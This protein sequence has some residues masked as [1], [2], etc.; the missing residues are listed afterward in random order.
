VQVLDAP[1]AHAA[2]VAQQPPAA[3]LQQPQAIHVQ[4]PQV[5]QQQQV[6]RVMAHF[7]LPLNINSIDKQQQLDGLD[8]LQWHGSVS[9][10][11]LV[12]LLGL[13][14][15]VKRARTALSKEQAAAAATPTAAGSS[16]VAS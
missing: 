7:G 10:G 2:A 15:A 3:S 11:R 5:Q 13:S 14:Q 6:S 16:S 12:E 9:E 1:A 4:L 8:S